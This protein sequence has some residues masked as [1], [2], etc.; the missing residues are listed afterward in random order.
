[1]FTGWARGYQPG[2]TTDLTASVERAGR[3]A[4]VATTHPALTHAT[5][6]PGEPTLL[7]LSR[8]LPRRSRGRSEPDGSFAT[9]ARL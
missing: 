4:L 1:M 8:I 9:P 5:E 6:A 2:L 3:A 7:R